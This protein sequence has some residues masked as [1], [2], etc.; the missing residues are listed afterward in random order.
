VRCEL[1]AAGQVLSAREE[2]IGIRSIELERT[3]TTTTEGGQ[4]LFRV[5]REPIFCKGSNW[6]PLDAFHSRDAGRYP[7]GS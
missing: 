5:N 7:R 6:V 3:D 4:F 1:V 2:R